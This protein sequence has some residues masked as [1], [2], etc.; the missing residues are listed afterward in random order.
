M[1]MVLAACLIIGIA[2]SAGGSL[3]IAGIL[4]VVV[5]LTA[6]ASEVAAGSTLLGSAG[7]ILLALTTFQGAFVTSAILREMRRRAASRTTRIHS[8]D[9]A[10][11]GTNASDAQIPRSDGNARG[12]QP[13]RRPSGSS[14]CLITQ[15]NGRTFGVG[16][17]NT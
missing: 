4:S 12:N 6:M 13:I 3:P 14:H 11:A 5:F 15:Q 7:F 2:A 10:R 8:G 1:I 17:R 16:D 9:R